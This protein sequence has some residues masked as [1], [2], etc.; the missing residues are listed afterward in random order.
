MPARVF[1][2]CGQ[3]SPEER[4]VAQNISAWFRS[5]GYLPYVAVT[6]QTIPDLNSGIIGALKESDYYLF[7]D[8]P[9]ESLS[10]STENRGSLY[11]HQELAAAYILDFHPMILISHKKVKNEG[12]KNFIVSNCPQFESADQ[13]P[14]LVQQAVIAAGWTPNFSRHLSITVRWG[15]CLIYRDQSTGIQGRSSKVL[16]G[17]V[18]NHRCD[19]AARHTICRLTAITDTIG[20]RNPSL[21]MTLLKAS[22]RAGYEHTIWPN[23]SEPFDLLGLDLSTPPNIYL[24]SSLDLVPRIPIVSSIGTFQFHYEILSEGF[25]LFPFTI[26]IENTG[27]HQTTTAIVC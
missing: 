19:F 9:R 8:F 24:H 25:P 1:I 3:A 20:L 5:Q 11:T 12:I 7:I 23:S 13:V 26:E 14:E 22:G 27:N 18:N 4:L 10:S 2:S 6:V 16:H 21:D 15:N 17:D